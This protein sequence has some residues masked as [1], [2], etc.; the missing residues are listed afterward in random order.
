MSGIDRRTFL[1]A[2]VGVAATTALLGDVFVADAPAHA[3]PD[4]SWTLENQVL[5]VTVRFAN[6]S[7]HLDALRNLRAGVEYLSDAPRTHLFVYTLNGATEVKADDGGWVL[8]STTENVIYAA[9]PGGNQRVGRQRVLVISRT[10][11]VPMRVTLYFELYDGSSGLRYFTRIKNN[12]PAAKLTISESVVLA[13]GIPSAPHETFYVNNMRWHSTTGPL[14]P[15]AQITTDHRTR[16]ERAKKAIVVY[17]AGHGWSLSPELNWKTQKGKGSEAEYMQPPFAGLNLWSGVTNVRIDTRPEVL[18]LVLF[19]NEEFE[20]LSV[21]FTVFTGTV[22]DGK[23]AEQ[24][25]FRRRFRYNNVSTL[26]NT[27]DWDWRSAARQNRYYRDVVVPKA[28]AAAMGMVMFD[29]LW[30]TTRDSIDVDPT[31]LP[32][33]GSLDEI[34]Q[35][36]SN[37]GMKFGMWFSLTGGY[38]N[39][40]RD[41][42]N[43]SELDAKRTQILALIENY[44]LEHQM[45]DLTEFWQN[46]AVTSYSHPTDN[47]YRKAVLSRNMLNGIVAEHPGF[48]VKLTSEVDI[49]PTQTD[50]TNGLLHVVDNGWLTA[51]GAVTDSPSIETVICSFG[52]LPMGSTYLAGKVSGRMEDYYSY[53]PV[54]NVKFP[55]D[56]GDPVAWPTAGITLMSKFNRWRAHPRISALTEKDFRPVYL[57][58]GWDTANWTTSVGPYAWMYLND[59][60]TRGLLVATAAGK[61]QRTLTANLRWL[62]DSVSYA[63]V[64][65]TLD[66]NTVFTYAYRGIRTG[67]A[68]K[69]PGLPIDLTQNTSA[70]KAFWIDTPPATPGIYVTYADHN[71]Q[72]AWIDGGRLLFTGKP[73]AQVTAVLI[74]SSVDRARFVQV[75]LSASGS[76]DVAIPTTGWVAPA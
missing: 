32:S 12:D 56:P 26:F 13:L 41:L 69:Q 46:D 48:G 59:D 52:H 43:H 33:I 23:M 29:D 57:G 60:R 31:L 24:T 3:A 74:D 54:R 45:I 1:R 42:A 67:A 4:D 14:S 19:P 65:I 63:I 18:Q 75:T 36:I 51:H 27:N 34:A 16:A 11:P 37:N 5:R 9:V 68:W 35:L 55:Q 6:G 58:Q 7:V 15:A 76:A 28:A 10:S 62:Y 49:F 40:G 70:G 61:S 72:R 21:N 66:D 47:V 2:G 20:Y 50:R 8:E 53:L 73:N 17:P 71:V 64:D 22:V 39:Q 30:N 44:G 25:H 38:H